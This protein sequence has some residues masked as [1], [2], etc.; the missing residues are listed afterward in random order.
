MI[1]AVIAEP[2]HSFALLTSL[3]VAG[4]PDEEQQHAADDEERAHDD[5]SQNGTGVGLLR[6]LLFPAKENT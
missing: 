5:G 3:G 6:V 2:M 4:P 1:G